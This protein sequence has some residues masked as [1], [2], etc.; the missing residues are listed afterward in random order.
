MHACTLGHE[1]SKMIELCH[2]MFWCANFQASLRGELTLFKVEIVQDTCEA[3]FLTKMSCCKI[4]G[5]LCVEFFCPDMP[6]TSLKQTPITLRTCM[7]FWHS[8]GKQPEEQK[9]ILP[10]IAMAIHAYWMTIYSR[11]LED[12]PVNNISFMRSSSFGCR[13]QKSLIESAKMIQNGHTVTAN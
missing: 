3:C 1:G 10:Y 4:L 7:H 12:V 11:F 2:G 5:I 8:C 13:E 6:W 9:T